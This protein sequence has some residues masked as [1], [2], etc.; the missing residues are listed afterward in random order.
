M[1]GFFLPWH[2]KEKREGTV[3]MGQRRLYVYR[4]P[5]PLEDACFNCSKLPYVSLMNW[6]GT[7]RSFLQAVEKGKREEAMGY[8]SGKVAP[9]VDYSEV[10]G[11]LQDLQ[12]YQ[13][14]AE[15]NGRDMRT[16]TVARSNRE[17]AVL[18]FRMVA[19]PDSYGKWKIFC[20]EKEGGE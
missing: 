12:G 3:P 8:F 15:E 16:V 11:L 9:A 1:T 6:K 17:G 13:C 4:P 18:S 20:I 19:E 10:E 2:K 7:L 14:F 5:K